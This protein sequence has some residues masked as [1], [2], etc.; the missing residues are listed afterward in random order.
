MSKRVLFVDDEPSILEIYEMLSP[1]FGE[2]YTVVTASG[3]QEALNRMDEQSFDAVVS[4]LTMPNMLG[5]E[6]LTE[7]SSRSPA[8][9]RI[10]VSGFADEMTTAKCLLVAHRYFSKP[11][12]PTVL[13]NVVI[14]L[15]DAQTKAA[16][17]KVREYVGKLE[18]L[19]TLSRTHFEL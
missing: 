3:G 9:A 11:F 16:N 5:I 2:E 12:N 6:F 14:S 13:T 7:V 15:C 18:A 17:D 10:V 8:T 19:P 4:D 1:F